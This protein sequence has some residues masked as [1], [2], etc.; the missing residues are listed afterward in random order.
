[1]THHI[2]AAEGLG[3]RPAAQFHPRSIGDD[4]APAFSF[5]GSSAQHP[6]QLPCWIT[7]TNLR[8]HEIIRGG[9]DRSRQHRARKAQLIRA[10]AERVVRLCRAETLVV[11]CASWSWGRW[12]NEK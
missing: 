4:P 3:G 6:R 7:Q 5:L 8:T 11:T 1:M 2:A 12:Q 9:L 10:S